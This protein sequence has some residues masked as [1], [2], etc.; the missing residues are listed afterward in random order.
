M[1][2][3]VLQIRWARGKLTSLAP[4]GPPVRPRTQ[5]DNSEPQYSRTD[6][7]TLHFG[8]SYIETE[9]AF[10]AASTLRKSQQ[11]E[12]EVRLLIESPVMWEAVRP[13][14]EALQ[15]IDPIRL[16]MV[17]YLRRETVPLKTDIGPPAYSLEA[18]F[19]WK[20]GT[21]LKQPGAAIDALT[22]DP[23]DVDSVQMARIRL[24]DEGKLDPR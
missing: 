3:H 9:Y 14:L 5:D 7:H 16:P 24:A 17:D 12:G 20:L 21:L 23:R 1:S 19:R 2:H 4:A 8:I 13:F 11:I 18:G 10:T 22:M 15:K 6:Q